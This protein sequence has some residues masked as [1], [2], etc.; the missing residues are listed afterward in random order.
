MIEGFWIRNFRS[1]RR[2]GIGSCFHLFTMVDGNPDVQPFELGPVTVFAGNSG[3]GKSTIL[4]AFTFLSDCF[5]HGLDYACQKRGGFDR[6]LNQGGKGDSFAMGIDVRLPTNADIATYAINIGCDKN[7][8]PFI[9]S[10]LLAVRQGEQSVPVIFLQNGSKSIR[11]LAP[12]ESLN[13]AD[14]TKVEFTDYKHLGLA[15]LERHSKFPFVESIRGLLEQWILSS[16]TADPAR[17]LDGSLPRRQYSPR[18]QSLSGLVRFI[19]Y[20]YKGETLRLLERVAKFLPNVE[21]IR[22]SAS[23]EDKPWLHFKM[24]DGEHPIPMTLLS[25]ATIRLFTFALLLEEDL[26]APLVAIEEPENG[27]DRPHRE[28]F[29]ELVHRVVDFPRP[30]Q[31]FL[32]THDPEL[33]AA[34]PASTIWILDRPNGEN[35]AERACDREE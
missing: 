29:L 7:R 5:Y 28:K 24:I 21:E 20:R 12:D 22:L 4:D 8:T 34:L 33:F 19:I 27:F 30:L 13:A 32:T 14:L 1:I 3:T 25:D 16:F 2:L 17:G 23:P 6:L 26:P 31:L 11:Y 15:N 35:V 9:K 10:E 18:G